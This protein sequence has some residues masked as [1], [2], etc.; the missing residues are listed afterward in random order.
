MWFILLNLSK[1]WAVMGVCII[2]LHFNGCSCRE[3]SVEFNCSILEQR[4]KVILV[5]VYGNKEIMEF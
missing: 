2:K 3:L 1:F 4:L 5:Y